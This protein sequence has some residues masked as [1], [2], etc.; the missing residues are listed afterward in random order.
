MMWIP[1]KSAFRVGTVSETAWNASNVGTWSFASGYN[2]LA[3]GETSTAIGGGTKA[4]GDF[5]S[6]DRWQYDCKWVRRNS[7]GKYN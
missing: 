4:T 6:C 7:Y 2:A 5:F 3:S 1:A